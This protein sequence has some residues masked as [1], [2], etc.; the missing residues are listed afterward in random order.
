MRRTAVG[1]CELA[2]VTARRRTNAGVAAAADVCGRLDGVDESVEVGEVRVEV[3][4]VVVGVGECHHADAQRAGLEDGAQLRQHLDEELA[5]L[6]ELREVHGAAGR[7]EQDYE[8]RLVTTLRRTDRRRGRR[9][10]TAR[11]DARL[12]TYS[13]TKSK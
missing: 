12:T 1:R 9:H 4:D 5:D 13:L 11:S 6:V 2:V 10:R 8:V 3:E 7:V